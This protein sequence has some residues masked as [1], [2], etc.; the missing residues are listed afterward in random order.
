[1]LDRIERDFLLGVAVFPARNARDRATAMLPRLLYERM[2]EIGLD[3]AVAYPSLALLFV[4]IKDHELQ[5]AAY[6]A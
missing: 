6:R 5:L 4:V 2:G 1:L 3:C